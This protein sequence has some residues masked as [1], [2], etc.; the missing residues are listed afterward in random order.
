QDRRG[1]EQS[2]E[3]HARPEPAAERRAARA[4]RDQVR[5]EREQRSDRRE[6]SA[7]GPAELRKH[8]RREREQDLEDVAHAP[9][10]ASTGPLS[11]STPVP[12][13]ATS[14]RPPRTSTATGERAAPRAMATTALA[15]APVP[16]A[17][18][19]PTPRSHV[20][21]RSTSAARSIAT[22]ST[23]VRAGKRA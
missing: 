1:A 3:Q 17:A 18:V 23:L 2:L 8:P 6:L 22:K 12:L 10:S 20:R 19:S 7:P 16:H 13:Q 4:E 9:G 5:H 14:R 11:V 15:P 21:T